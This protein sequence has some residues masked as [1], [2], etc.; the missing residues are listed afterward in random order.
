MLTGI[1][2]SG[3][4]IITNGLVLHLDAAQL[5]SYPTT[6]TTWTDLS[7]N[8]NNGTLT[9]GPTFN[10]GNGGSIVFDGVNDYVQGPTSTTWFSNT[11]FSIEAWVFPNSSPPDYQHFFAANS[12]FTAR[13]SLIL[14]VYNTGVLRFGYYEDDLDASGIT[15]NTWN[16]VIAT[17]NTTGDL[18]SVYINGNFINSSNAGPYVAT[19]ANVRIGIWHY[20]GVEKPWKGRIAVVKVYNRPLTATE[21]LQNFNATKSR[22]GL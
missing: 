2:D 5:R 4:K 19:S 6:G 1:I 10:S 20:P 9:N 14:R 22:Y 17:Y 12:S 8:G 13:R 21:V 7:G 15:F 16:H 3:Q 11:S 18:S